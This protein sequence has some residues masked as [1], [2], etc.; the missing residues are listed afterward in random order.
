MQYPKA[1]YPQGSLIRLPL[2][3]KIISLTQKQQPNHLYR[4]QGTTWK[5][6]QEK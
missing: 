4:L 6:V 1:L 2:P 5:L 3:E